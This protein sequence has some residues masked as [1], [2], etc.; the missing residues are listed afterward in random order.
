MRGCHPIHACLALWT[1]AWWIGSTKASGR[2]TTDGAGVGGGGS[3]EAREGASDSA[4]VPAAWSMS[5]SGLGGAG[6]SHLCHGTAE[7]LGH[8]GH[9]SEGGRPARSLDAA[10][11]ASRKFEWR[12][13]AHTRGFCPTSRGFS[14]FLSQLDKADAD[15]LPVR[16]RVDC[17]ADA[18][19]AEQIGARRARTGHRE[20]AAACVQAYAQRTRARRHASTLLSSTAPCASSRRDG[21]KEQSDRHAPH[22]RGTGRAVGGADVCL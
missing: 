10:S 18:M 8:T 3:D 11:I 16:A 19:R 12:T 20:L 4:G 22:A 14:F 2:A 5:H 15:E 1:K 13:R 7:V 9:C 21:Q 17:V 6:A